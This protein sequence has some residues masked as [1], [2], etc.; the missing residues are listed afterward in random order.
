MAPRKF[1]ETNPDGC[2]RVSDVQQC[3]RLSGPGFS[4]LVGAGRTGSRRRRRGNRSDLVEIYQVEGQGQE[5]LL[6]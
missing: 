6:V 3:L 1:D 2:Y 4:E 5:S